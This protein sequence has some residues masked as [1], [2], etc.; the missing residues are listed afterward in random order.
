[1]LNSCVANLSLRFL[2]NMFVYETRQIGLYVFVVDGCVKQLLYCRTSIYD[3]SKSYIPAVCHGIA[4][5][6][7]HS[8][9]APRESGMCAALTICRADK[10]TRQRNRTAATLPWTVVTIRKGVGT[11]G[12]T[13]ALA[14][15][16]IRQV[17]QLVT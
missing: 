2:R 8:N 14:P 16:I 1:M 10:K 12:A 15:A 3:A 9:S 13:G 5:H 6:A 7:L 4:V 17:Y 11:A